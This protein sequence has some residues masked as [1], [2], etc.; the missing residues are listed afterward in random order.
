MSRAGALA[1]VL[2]L[3]AGCEVLVGIHDKTLSGSAGEAGAGIDDGGAAVDGNDGPYPD[4]P[5]SLQP[6]SPSPFFC[7]DFDEVEDAGHGWGYALPQQGG[8]IAIDSQYYRSRPNSAQVYAPPNASAQA[9]LGLDVP[10]GQGLTVAFDLRVDVDDLTQLPPQVGVLQIIPSSGSGRSILYSLGNQ[11]AQILVSDGTGAMTGGG[12]TPPPGRIWTRLVFVYDPTQG[13]TAF[14]DGQ[15][16]T[17]VPSLTGALTG[18]TQVILGADYVYDPATGN[19][20]FQ[21]QLDNVV[22]WND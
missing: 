8:S 7:A 20:A 12:T 18:M 6:Q 13:L 1:A 5:C 3:V 17:G 19:E 9:Q 15:M 14:E 22:V 21:A 4:V 2:G 16:L 11:G 10:T